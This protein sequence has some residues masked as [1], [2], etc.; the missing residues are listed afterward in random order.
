MVVLNGGDG[1]NS[2]NSSNSSNGGDSSKD[3]LKSYYWGE[4]DK[5]S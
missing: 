1:S 4:V 5:Y 2:S 3:I